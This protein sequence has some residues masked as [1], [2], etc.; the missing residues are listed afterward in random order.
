MTSRSATLDRAGDS[1]AM[2]TPRFIIAATMAVV[3]GSAT[4]AA[5]QEIKLADCP[6]AV[7]KTFE[8]EARGSKI[9]AVHRE[10]V[11]DETTYWAEVTVGGK[12]YAV[13]VLQDG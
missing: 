6:D 10:K 5:G 3:C 12:A 11:E 4:D 2:P 8:A 1:F 7:R 13:A 9:A